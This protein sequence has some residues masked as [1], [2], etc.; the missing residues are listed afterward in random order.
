M[1][2]AGETLDSIGQGAIRVIQ[3]RDGYRFNLDSVLL[4]HFA[5]AHNGQVVDLGTGCGIIPLLMVE[6]GACNITGVELQASLYD[7]AVRNVAMNNRAGQVRLLHG[8]IRVIR[9]LLPSQSFDLVVCNPP[10][11]AM[12]AGS[13][14]PNDER[15][16]ARHE[17]TCCI[18]KLAEAVR[19]LLKPSGSA[20]IVYPTSRIP[21]LFRAFDLGNGNQAAT[22]DARD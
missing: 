7:L 18:N 12:N 15:A 9:D 4:A 13:I 21:D 14:S 6:Q 1:I 8:D 10:Y 22:L 19:Y 3:R 20:K 17:T 2:L 5:G 11:R 16:K